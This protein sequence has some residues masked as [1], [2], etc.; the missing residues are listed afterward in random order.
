MKGERIIGLVLL[1]GVSSM[2]V[3]AKP[4]G[5]PQT[6][7]ITVEE[8]MRLDYYL[9]AAL[10]AQ[11]HKQHA[12]AYFLLELCKNIDAKN[13]TVNALLGSYNASLYGKEN[14]LPLLR[15]AY[16]GS[17]S[18]YWYQYTITAYEAGD[19]ATA[20]KV[21]K[22]REKAEPKNIDILELH[23]HI[24]IHEHKY[25][26]ALAIRDK[27]DKLTGEPTLPS[28]VARYE[29][30]RSMGEEAK[31]LHVLDSYLERNPNE[32]RLRAMRADIDLMT[33]KRNNDKVA[34]ERLLA[35]QLHSADVSLP[36]KL[37]L[38][39]QHGAWLDYDAAK[40]KSWL[41]E[42]REQYPYEQTIYQA[43]LNHEE[44][45]GNM[46]AALEI[47]RTML[48]MNP[49]D[50]ELREKIAELMRKDEN[51]TT[52]EVGQFIDESYAILPDDPKW[53]YFKALRCWQRDDR[54]S[55]LLVLENAIA[56]ASEPMVKIELLALYG[57]LLGQEGE[58]E[59]AFAAYDEVL[60]LA[61]DHLSVLNN[62]AWTLAISGGDLKKAEKMSQRTIQKDGN[63]P[64]FLDTYAWIL[65]LQGQDTLALF[66]IKRAME[67]ATDKSDP[68]I[69]EHYN[70]IQQALQ[71]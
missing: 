1:L 17:P 60:Q 19:R 25:K 62:Y 34:G 27:I 10:N 63:N 23:E 41:T 52:E 67:Y 32:G 38:L 15:I 4:K 8:Q 42:L 7:A 66:Y 13:P 3:W 5:K 12:Q 28:V 24:F 45:N 46:S 47:G 58:N 43:L 20:L 36:N 49:T 26:Q 56:H 53:G 39:K 2:L 55:T 44:E 16:E 37:K 70:T 68:T 50:N 40:K 64:T 30:Y 59:K 65:H 54:D 61:P 35:Q 71:Q 48:R 6:P 14:A 21:L 69:Q 9:Y 57:D 31:A 11:E 22:D 18:D 33:A 51:V 29:L